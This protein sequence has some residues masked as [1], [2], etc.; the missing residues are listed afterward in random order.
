MGGFKKSCWIP[1]VMSNTI[2]MVCI[3]LKSGIYFVSWKL[4]K[5]WKHKTWLKDLNKVVYIRGHSLM[6]NIGE[7]E[8]KRKTLSSG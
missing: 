6:F 3:K 7:L 1:D 5:Y 2:E 8:K 4:P